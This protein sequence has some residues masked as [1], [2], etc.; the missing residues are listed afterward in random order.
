MQWLMLMLVVLVLVYACMELRGLATEGTDLY[1]NVKA[2]HFS[3]GLCD[4]VGGFAVR[5]PGGLGSGSGARP[6]MPGWQDVPSRLM[7]YALYA[8]MIATPILG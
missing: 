8:F 5:Y 6:P 4:R 1:N 2:L 7:H 3:L